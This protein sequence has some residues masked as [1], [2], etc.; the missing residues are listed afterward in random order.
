M[1]TEHSF[2][3][4][5]YLHLTNHIFIILILYITVFDFVQYKRELNEILHVFDKQFSAGLFG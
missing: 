5:F 2:I 4:T 1:L 3:S